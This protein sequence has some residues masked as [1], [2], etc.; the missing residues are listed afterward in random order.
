MIDLN[1]LLP[2]GSEADDDLE[3]IQGNIIN[4]HGR[5]HTCHIMLK[6]IGD[7][8]VVKRWIA[9]FAADHVTSARAARRQS[10]A[11]R[12]REGTGEPFAMFLLSAHG[13]RYLGFTDAKLPAPGGPFMQPDHEQYFRLG[14][15]KQGDVVGDARKY[16]DLPSDTWEP[17]YQQDIDA[18]VLLANADPN[19]LKRSKEEVLGLISGVFEKITIEHGDA[20]E[21]DFPNPH[22]AGEEPVSKVIEHFGFQDGV[23]QPIMMEEKLKKELAER[24]GSHWDPAASLSLVLVP[25]PDFTDR[26]GSFMVFRKLEQNVKAFSEAL[27]RLASE[28]GFSLED[29]GAMAVGRY[30]DGRPAIPTSTIDPKADPNDFHFDQDPAG[31]K[32]PFHAHIRKTNPRGDLPRRAAEQGVVDPERLRRLGEGER[33]MRIARRG[34]TYDERRDPEDSSPEEG[35]GLLFMCF[36]ANLEQFVI[37]QEGSDSNSFVRPGT[38]FDAVIGQHNGQ[39]DVPIKQT[40]PSNGAFKFKMVDFVR[41]RGGEYFF[42]PSMT[43]LKEL[44]QP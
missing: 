16:N 42:A 35:V 32:C 44:S 23:S 20:I 4:G 30:Q 43:F 10:V 12:A 15:K 25:E 2:E 28:S 41:M 37:Q 34:I 19:L 24:G 9:R 39:G 31:G 18:M 36:Q 17:A 6:M 38:G 21:K 33:A 3:K 27:A 1:R 29:G 40:W 22:G 26:F 8:Q 11:W 7:P 13:Y 5:H 14:M